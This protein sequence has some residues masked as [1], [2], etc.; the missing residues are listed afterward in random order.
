MV[1]IELSL[2]CCVPRC[3]SNYK[4]THTKVP[5]QQF[6]KDLNEQKKWICD[7]PHTGL[8]VTKYSAVCQLHW[9]GEAAFVID[10]GKCVYVYVCV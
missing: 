5:V 4:S 3:K 10:H 1:V 7:I 9:R 8:K 2:K 6:P